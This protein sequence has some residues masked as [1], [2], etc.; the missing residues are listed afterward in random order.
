MASTTY[1]LDFKVAIASASR[2]EMLRFSS[3][4][5]LRQRKRGK[6]QKST[7]PDATGNRNIFKAPLKL[8][9][10]KVTT[11]NH[12]NIKQYENSTFLQRTNR[13]AHAHAHTRTY[14]HAFNAN[15]V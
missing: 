12:E 6:T 5:D 3:H 15:G 2:N 13:H 14:N 7:F 10:K 8:Q 9:L 1:R 4:L 11:K